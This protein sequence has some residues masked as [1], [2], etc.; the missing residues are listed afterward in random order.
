MD[1]VL[2]LAGLALLL[3]S[4]DLLVR[5]A[6]GLSLRLGIPALI[7][8]LTVVALGTSAPELLVSVQ[9]ALR[10]APDIALGNVVGS[11]ISN[12]LLVL[13]LPALVAALD[14]SGEDTRRS[15]AM[16]LAASVLLVG[17]AFA[18]PLGLA[19][20][21]ILLLCFGLMLGDMARAAL[22]GRAPGV[23][24]IEGAG[25]QGPL[26][27]IAGFL[28]L[29]LVGLPL[30]AQLLIDG[31]VGLATRLGIA[32]AVIG[33]T[34]VAVGTS[35]PELATCVAA[36]LRARTDVVF[37][38]VIGSN[39]FNILGILGITSL[40]GPLAVAPS[41]LERDVWVLLAAGLLLVPVVFFGWRITRAAGA[42]FL[43]LYGGY[44][45]TL[46]A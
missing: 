31:A 25:S 4:G 33:L 13:G 35:L 12:S 26:L 20:A 11:N 34:L 6:V 15:Y 39:L 38:N 45:Y 36:A 7:V 28:M 23:A 5:G 2:A 14:P 19:H 29:G 17:L 30:G 3:V 37:G 44:T 46:F 24:A 40:F 32:E 43:I 16:M 22:A 10:G 1:L 8:G 27:P 21:A 42:G 41:F 18:G 9:A